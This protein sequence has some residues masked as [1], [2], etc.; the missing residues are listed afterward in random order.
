MTEAAVRVP[1]LLTTRELADLT[2]LP[3]FTVMRL[4]AEGKG[5]PSV[6]IGWAYRFAEDAV[7]EWIR[8]LSVVSGK[9]ERP[10][11]TKRC[12]TCGRDVDTRMF[13]QDWETNPRGECRKCRRLA[14]EAKNEVSLR[15]T[16]G[17]QR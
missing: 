3:Y 16:A 12:P 7:L 4:L 6:R 17:G 9:V 10:K 2:G 11:V 1:R 14:A 15:R 8:T 13:K 5:P